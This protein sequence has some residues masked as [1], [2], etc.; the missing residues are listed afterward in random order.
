MTEATHTP[1]STANEADRTI[2]QERLFDAPREL[3]FQAWTD[4]AHLPRW[5]GPKGFHNTVQE[6]K[7]K[8][9]GVW[10]FTMHGPD[11][12]DWNNVVTFIEIVKNERIVYDHGDSVDTPAHFQVTATFETVGN[13]TRLRM[14]MVFPTAEACEA[15]KKF[16]AIES[17]QQT[18]DKLAALLA[19]QSKAFTISRTFDAPRDL[20]YKAS[21]EGE[22]L[23]QWWGPKGMNIE[24]AK[25]DVRPGGVFHYRLAND[26][27]AEMWGKFQYIEMSAPERIVFISSF[28]DA[29]GT[30]ARAPFPGHFPLEV[31]NVWTFTE[32]NGK[33]TLT[34]SGGPFNAT[35]EEQ[36]FYEGMTASMQQGF[37]G[38]FD[39]LE[40]YL[41]KATKA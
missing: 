33:T 1:G 31:Y 13:Q 21:T 7:V 10:R 9:G 38:T 12:K 20:V 8:P 19:N 17:G 14:R 35:E 25:L 40:T 27:G 24:I 32:E 11:G 34:I 30:T 41:E 36:A 37:G 16:G 3:V 4:P 28:S 2:I 6:I 23:A 18:L 15:V 22:R 39:Q 26:Q 29:E 5:F